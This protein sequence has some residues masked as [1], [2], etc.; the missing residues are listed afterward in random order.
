M[1]SFVVVFIKKKEFESFVS[2]SHKYHI[3]NSSILILLSTL[4][5]QQLISASVSVCF[6]FISSH[7]NL[8]Y[9]Y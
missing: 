8:N 7:F 4:N 2:L 1:S 9:F 5:I 6:L 3:P